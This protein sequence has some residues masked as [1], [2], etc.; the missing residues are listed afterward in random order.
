MFKLS[1]KVSYK[2]AVIGAGQI[3]RP[4]F[5][6]LR[7]DNK[8][9]STVTLYDKQPGEDVEPLDVLDIV[10][11][12]RAVEAHD[13]IISALPYDVTLAVASTTASIGGKVYFDLTEDL[14][15][16]KTLRQL[17]AIANRG[18]IMV[19]H[20]GLA[21]GA[22]SIIAAALARTFTQVTDIKLRVGAL[23]VA[24][25]NALQYHRSWSTVGLVNEYTKPCKAI[26]R[27]LDGCEEVIL[28]PLED[29]MMV[30]YDG[31]SYEAFNTSGGSGTL[32]ESLLEGRIC[33]LKGD[34]CYQSMRY[35]GHRD[36]MKFLLED[37]GFKWD[38]PALV[39]LLD[40]EVP[41]TVHDVVVVLIQVTGSY[42]GH[43][44]FISTYSKKIYGQNGYSAI[45]TTTAGSLVSV[46]HAVVDALDHGEL[47]SLVR[48]HN[49]ENKTGSGWIAN[50]DIKLAQV[51]FDTTWASFIAW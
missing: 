2:A 33:D 10:A 26:H 41:K 20:C 45:Q 18:T 21:P 50:E 31:S 11:L 35:P 39:R 1:K 6:M 8:R 34:M 22:V 38:L 4:I 48:P 9:F 49:A 27:T 12:N 28:R 17:N 3:G 23:P 7:H 36:K 40:R 25:D 30:N 51:M 14:G 47:S 15:N 13:I 32:H 42:N 24:C 5:E 46:V 37:M 29:L 16:G 44:N 19:P 43:E